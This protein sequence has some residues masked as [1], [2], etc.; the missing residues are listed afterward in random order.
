MTIKITDLLVKDIR[1]PTSKELAGSDAMNPDPDYSAA[2]V[3]LK[4]DD[5]ALV[6]PWLTFTLGRGT[7]L[8]VVHVEALR[9]LIVDHDVE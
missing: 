8:S 4:T 1:F 7:E 2:Y 5:A 9:R 3:I 6:W